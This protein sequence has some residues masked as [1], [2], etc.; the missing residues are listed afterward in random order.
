MAGIVSEALI[1]RRSLPGHLGADAS[2]VV[3]RVQ[4][5]VALE[6]VEDGEVRGLLTVGDRAAFEDQPA[7]GA[8][9]CVNS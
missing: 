6:Q 3:A 1:Q 8:C 5:E 4:L 2:A 7:V 9:A